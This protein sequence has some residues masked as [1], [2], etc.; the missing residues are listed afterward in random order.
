[1][2]FVASA[3][4]TAANWQT[5]IVET[6]D[7]NSHVGDQTP[8]G[9]TK[10]G[11]W[12]ELSQF[13]FAIYTG[14]T[15][16][17][18]GRTSGSTGGTVTATCEDI[19]DIN[20]MHVCTNRVEGAAVLGGDSGAPVFYPTDG[21]SPTYIM[22]ILWGGTT[23]SGV[24][25]SSY[26]FWFTDWPTIQVH[27]GNY[28]DPCSPRVTVTGNGAPHAVGNYT[29]T[30]NVSHGDL[31]PSYEWYYSDDDVTYTDLGVST[32]HYTRYVGTAED[33]FLKV[34]VADCY[35]SPSGGIEVMS[36]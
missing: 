26:C 17:K 5:Q 27:L 36:R 28:F 1:V 25:C 13:P 10:L 29:Y 32:Q 8:G 3:D 4:T 9:L 7:W 12:T 21:T 6:T 35:E 15:L 23:D 11:W 34:I 14:Q 20:A 22:G 18:V 33:F 30:A 16:Y 2:M 24:G 19:G 31:S